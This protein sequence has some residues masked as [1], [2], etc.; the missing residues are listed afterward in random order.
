MTEDVKIKIT[1]DFDEKGINRLKNSLK[2]VETQANTTKKSFDQI[3]IGLQTLA[4]GAI[5]AFIVK[6]VNMGAELNVLRSNFIGSAKDIE[7]FRKATAGTV[8]DGSL[9]KL[10]NYASDL[11]V[12]LEDQA[13]L[14]S[15]AEDA[16]DKYGGSVESNFE[17]VINASDGSARGLR[18]VGVST[19]DFE[20]ELN[21]LVA[22]TG[23]HLDALDAEEQQNLR[24]QA[25]F[26]L[27]GVSIQSVNDKTQDT[28]DKMD[29]L[30]VT[31]TNLVSSFGSG[32][33]NSLNNSAEKI[34]VLS[35]ALEKAGIKLTTFND[36]AKI[37]GM[38]LGKPIAVTMF[39]LFYIGAENAI[40]KLKEFLN[41]RPGA[42]QGIIPSPFQSN[43]ES[44]IQFDKFGNVI[45]PSGYFAENTKYT[46]GKNL[47]YNPQSMN[48][49]K[50]GTVAKEVKIE[51]NE[52]QRLQ[53]DLLK[54]EADKTSYISLYGEQAGIVLETLKEI[55][56]TQE[57]INNLTSTRVI[58]DTSGIKLEERK[59]SL[60]SAEDI[61]QAQ[62]QAESD[63]IAG[64]G[65]E[66]SSS[67]LEDIQ[68]GYSLIAQSMSLL[69]IG[70]DTFVG[71]LMTFFGLVNSAFDLGSSIVKFVTSII[72]GVPDSMISGGNTSVDTNRLINQNIS[73]SSSPVNIYMSSNVSQKYFKAQIESYNS[74]KQYTKI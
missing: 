49:G 34:G 33:A 58:Y 21:K 67:T 73:M 56:D 23:K 12:A 68:T 74:M 30:Q 72:P 31:V 39:D 51:L 53:Q 66:D 48:G 3:G 13:K 11:G 1:S 38:V 65:K 28:K 54:L 27:T 69:N 29:S 57:K 14:F 24:L 70:T 71:K 64:L 25:I 32:F 59:M 8:D 26:N 37:T 62:Y 22:T 36:L 16:A 9:I 20:Q 63:Y 35:N 15:L 19:K 4:S 55:K 44:T 5:T 42:E 46:G 2:T 18:A 41:L 10:S 43:D 47:G 52:I 17:R 6:A 40:S 7:L 50:G 60:F 61:R 45:Y